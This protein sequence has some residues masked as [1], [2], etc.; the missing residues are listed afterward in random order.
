MP[1]SMTAATSV[2]RASQPEPLVLMADAKAHDVEL[3]AG[4]SAAATPARSRTS[5][6]DKPPVASVGTL[7]ANSTALGRAHRSLAAATWCR[8]PAGSAATCSSAVVCPLC[9]GGRADAEAAGPRHVVD[10][11]PPQLPQ[12]THYLGP[13]GTDLGEMADIAARLEVAET[14]LARTGNQAERADRLRIELMDERDRSQELA[15]ALLETRRITEELQAG[16]QAQAEEFGSFIRAV[17]ANA[18]GTESTTSAMDAVDSVHRAGRTVSLHNLEL[19]DEHE[20][21][22][23]ALCEELAEASRLAEA[24]PAMEWRDRIEACPEQVEHMEQLQEQL[25]E[26]NVLHGRVR[27]ETE[28]YRR[29][30]T[31]H[32]SRLGRSVVEIH[33]FRSELERS[34]SELER[35]SEEVNTYNDRVTRH[36][37]EL[38]HEAMRAATVAAELDELHDELRESRALLA[39]KH[40]CERH[41]QEVSRVNNTASPQESIAACRMVV[42]GAVLSKLS[43]KKQRWQ[44]RWVVLGST[45]PPL[46]KWTPDLKKHTFGY[47]SNQLNLEEVTGIHWLKGLPPKQRP[48]QRPWNCFALW[49]SR[50]SYFFWTMDDQVAEGFVIGLSRLSPHAPPI[51]GRDVRL[52]R[53]LFKIGPDK[54]SRAA[55]LS[56]A[57]RSCG[58]LPA[59]QAAGSGGRASPRGLS[60]VRGGIAD[61][62]AAGASSPR[63]LGASSNG[64]ASPADSY[65]SDM[66]G[67]A[68][69]AATAAAVAAGGR[70]VRNTELPD[71]QVAAEAAAADEVDEAGSPHGGLSGGGSSG[72]GGDS[73]FE[74][75]PLSPAG[76]G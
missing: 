64:T 9:G 45:S 66:D 52:H 49:A 69:A 70:A 63:A 18:L 48:S 60:T 11:L 23:R 74:I 55:A 12:P 6:G 37:T 47:Q 51:S 75:E 5:L 28:D 27:L 38:D 22:T 3:C 39:S 53:V 7:E 13:D 14:L 41:R 16:F 65:A 42:R 25:H 1:L 36:A 72:G 61:D 57:F 4:L 10:Q 35:S 40:A 67:Q 76:S 19:V 20:A 32:E 2:W 17:R 44:E 29:S 24:Q 54:K 34:R 73:E 56:E 21:A 30:V 71:A 31:E 46:L 68:Q 62:S 26:E 50:R 43:A 8:P 33:D 15:E 58:P 59:R